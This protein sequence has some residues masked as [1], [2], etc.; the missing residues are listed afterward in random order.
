[1]DFLFC[2]DIESEAEERLTA[3]GSLLASKIIKVPHH[4][5]STSIYYPFLNLIN[6]EVGIISCGYKNPYGH[7]HSRVL[8]VYKNLGVKIYRTDKNGAI[9]VSSDGKSYK[10]KVTKKAILTKDRELW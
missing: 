9:I 8:K 7:P 4:G 10:I 2:A 6:P 1:V 3:Y 5:S